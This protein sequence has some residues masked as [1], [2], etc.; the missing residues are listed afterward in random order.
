MRKS[1]ASSPMEISGGSHRPWNTPC[2]TASSCCGTCRVDPCRWS[3]STAIKKITALGPVRGFDKRIRPFPSAY[4]Q[5]PLAA[6]HHVMGSAES[7][8]G[9]LSGPLAFRNLTCDQFGKRGAHRRGIVDIVN[10]RP[11]DLVMSLCQPQKI[12]S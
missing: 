3:E 2:R 4:S 8:W 11:F 6:C 9:F 1:P 10:V 12:R 7:S 5:I